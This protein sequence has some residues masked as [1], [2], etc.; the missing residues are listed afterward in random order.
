MNI[1]IVGATGLVGEEFIKLIESNHLSIKINK[2]KLFAS[3]KSA[4]K[5]ITI[6]NNKYI[7]EEV[8]ERSFLNMNVAIFCCSSELSL[9]YSKYAVSSGCFVIDNS[10]AFR[11]LKNIPLILPEVN[12]NLVNLSNGIISNPN[13]CVCMLC[14]VL[15]PLHKT[16]KISKII[17]S[18][19]QSASGSGRKGLDELEKQILNYN[20]G[21]F[22]TSVFGRKYINN[23]FSHNSKVNL[24]NGYNE[25]EIKIIQETNKILDSNLKIDVT[26]VRVPVF[27][28]HCISVNI[29]FENS[30]DLEKIYNLLKEREGIDIVDDRI[31]GIFPEPINT[32]NTFNIQVG[33]IRFDISDKN[34]KTINLFISGDQLLKGAALN[35]YQILNLCQN[36]NINKKHIK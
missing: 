36:I 33:R 4:G 20:N 28:S 24:E 25:E 1:G 5:I 19:Y 18:T 31:N 11:M 21:S 2:M 34:M 16:F 32:E 30:V 23:I 22:D 14:L 13:C 17:M 6:N 7:I 3:I 26:C 8:N 29:E 27:R 15:A 10:S 35:A 9:K 12:G